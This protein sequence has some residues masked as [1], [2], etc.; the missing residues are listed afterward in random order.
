MQ[1]MVS[2]GNIILQ[3]SQML[4]K[5]NQQISACLSKRRW[6][7]F[8]ARNNIIHKSLQDEWP[9]KKLHFIKNFLVLNVYV[10]NQELTLW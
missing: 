1:Y 4:Q 9:L 7:S 2:E 3:E 8:L 6:S 5:W 10:F